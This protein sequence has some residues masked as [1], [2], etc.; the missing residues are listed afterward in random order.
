MRKTLPQ[1]DA[2]SNFEVSKICNNLQKKGKNNYQYYVDCN[3][4]G[5]ASHPEFPKS[6][7][8]GHFTHH[9]AKLQFFYLNEGK[10]NKKIVRVVKLCKFCKFGFTLLKNTK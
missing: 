2:Q 7:Q 1:P 8:D 9:F 10:R 3:F 5:R 6:W 4:R